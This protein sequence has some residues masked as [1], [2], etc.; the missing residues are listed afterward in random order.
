MRSLFSL[1][2]VLIIVFVSIQETVAQVTFTVT[3]T[4]DTG[5]GSLRQAIAEANANPGADAIHFNIPGSGPH[6]IQLQSALPE[7][8]GPVV[9]DGL[10]QS[11]ANCSSWPASLQIV[12]DGTA[13]TGSGLFFTSNGS[14]VRGLVIG[15][16]TSIGIRIDGDSNA[17]TCTYVG[18]DASGT[19]AAPNRFGLALLGDGNTVGGASAT[20]RVLVSGNQNDGI[21]I[22]GTANSVLG[23]YI[24]TNAT[25]IAALPN[26]FGIK[27]E[28]DDAVIGMPEAGNLISGNNSAGVYIPGAGVV[29]RGNRIGT[30]ATGMD[31]LGNLDGV[32]VLE[33]TGTVIGGTEAGARNLVSGNRRAGLSLIAVSTTVVQGNWVGTDATGLAPLGNGTV[34]LADAISLFGN[35]SHSG[36]LIG[37]A[38]EAEGNV[39]VASPD[40]GLGVTGVSGTIIQNNRIGI[41]ADGQTPL[42]NADDGI[43]LNQADGTTVLDNTISANVEN[44]IVAD[45]SEGVVVRGNHIGT[46]AGG[47]LDRGNGLSAILLREG[48]DGAAIGG[49]VASHAN[50]LAHNAEA[51]VA[52][53][54]SEGVRVSRNRTF[55][56]G[57]LGIDLQGDGITP[58][59]AG[60]ADEGPNRLQNFPEFT[61]A[62]LSGS[63][64]T[65]EGT[66][67]STPSTSF[68]IEFFINDAADPS[69]FGEGE[70]FIGSKMVSTD[71]SGNTAVDD[72]FTDPSLATGRFV[73]ATATDADGNTSEFSAVIEAS[74]AENGGP[75]AQDDTSTTD[76][77]VATEI[78]VLSNDTD[79]DGDALT[80][81]VTDDPAS[82]T[83]EV[84]DDQRILYTPDQDFSG[85]DAFTYQVADGQGGNSQ[86]IVTVTVTPVNDAPSAPQITQPADAAE[87]SVGGAPGDD[88]LDPETAVTIAWTEA[89]DVEG[90]PVSYTWQLATD[91]A[92][93]E[94]LLARVT[95]GATTT[96]LTLAQLAAVLDAA[97]VALGAE[98]VLYHRAV[99]SDGAAE[100]AG[101]AATVRL[102]RGTIT[103]TADSEQPAAFALEAN[104]PNPFNVRTTIRYSLPEA[105]AVDLVVFDMLGRHVT[106]LLNGTRPAGLHEAVFDA[107]GLPTGVYLYRLEAGRYVQTRRMLHV[108]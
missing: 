104:A 19:T 66:L 8:T 23:S 60:D 92:F 76:E 42:P 27:V 91:E 11:G 74:V 20:D 9:I 65:V 5:A 98:M 45:A 93:A 28:G 37:G 68:H 81:T 54:G 7:I 4:N 71:A 83:A 2:A 80:V 75:T 35:S 103:H 33:T 67:S 47:T 13:T 55:N 100:T 61:G 31:A 101:P 6:T 41:G 16:F 3:N 17:V 24:G 105:S 72:S 84:L 30:D 15:G 95:D 44:G 56:N 57:G 46:D 51:G 43:D 94:P 59:D 86:A 26:G 89:A 88:P 102:V 14:T 18:T 50:I 58:N 36:N 53:I 1:L 77:D 48:S 79:P 22:R 106:T 107:S 73:A 85:E 52:I 78:D 70:R 62:T 108:R 87:I 39:I 64:L 96:D 38:M 49:S 90:D 12:L 69:G 97:G 34:D 82:G 21:T 99:A 29:V 40:D 25:G 10:S 63:T 32:V